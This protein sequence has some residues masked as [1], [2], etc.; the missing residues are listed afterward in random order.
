[1][2]SAAK[3][4]PTAIT[5][6]ITKGSKLS[7]TLIN[8]MSASLS[9]DRRHLAGHPDAILPVRMLGE[10]LRIGVDHLGHRSGRCSRVYHDFFAES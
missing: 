8:H 6:V 2:V 7:L 1:M 10:E 3:D 9:V 5:T 4:N